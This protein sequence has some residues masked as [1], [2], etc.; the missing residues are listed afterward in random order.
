MKKTEL[1]IP[2][3]GTEQ[4]IAAVENGA[5]AV[6]VGGR[7][8]NARMNADNFSDEEMQ[9]AVDFAHV[10][11]VKVYVAMNTLVTDE[12]LAE[13]ADYAGFLYEAGVD[14]LI[15]QD[16]GLGMLIRETMSDFPLHFST[17]GSVYD[18]RGVETAARLGYERVV[19]ARELSFNE[20]RYICE[21]TDTEIEVFVHGAL[22]VC[23][24]GQCQLSRCHGGRSGNRGEC[25]QPCRLEYK[26]FDAVGRAVDTVRYPLSPKD[27]CLIDHI[28]EL[29]E[30]GVASLKVEG[31]MKSPEY[32]AI[33]TSIYR[34]YLDEY[35][36]NGSYQVTADDREALTQIFSRGGFT[37]G[38]WNGDPG[39]E[40]MSGNIPKHQ[41]VR[42]GKVIKKVTG[43]CLVD[44]KL[45]D[46]LQIGDGVEIHGRH[47]TGNIVTYYKDLKGG[48]TRIGDIKGQV[49]HGDILYRTSRKS[50][51][52]DARRSFENK[53]FAE[54]RFLRKRM[55]DMV[56]SADEDGMISLSVSLANSPGRTV[57]STAESQPTVT[58]T[59]GSFDRADDPSAAK[60]RMENSLR[61]T[62]STPFAVAEI[63]FSEGFDRMAPSSAIN[64]LRRRALSEL[65]KCFI[66]RR[67]KAA[68][69]FIWNAPS[70]SRPKGLEFW[71][72]TWEGFCSFTMPAEL[73]HSDA[74]KALII[75]VTAFERH[76]GELREMAEAAAGE[77]VRII[78]Y[79]SDISKGAEDDYI[80][81]HF[82]SICQ[83]AEASGIY[84]GSLS[85]VQPF[86]SEGIRVYGDYGLNVC[87]R[88][89]AA[90][91]AGIGIKG[92]ASSLE[93]MPADG[94][95]GSFPYMISQ[96]DPE[97]DW[98][99][100]RK[101]A[102]IRIVRREES[103][104]TLLIPE[105]DILNIHAIR[106]ALNQENDNE[107]V[108]IYFI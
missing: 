106:E 14:A 20:I 95:M 67:E 100:D 45:Y 57:D 47:V 48:L 77:G 87:N 10:R 15:I 39:M 89:S 73:M 88:S 6:Y 99:L 71:F 55:I 69:V 75:P 49:E 9:A 84:V 46:S 35:Y 105:P 76:F 74:E 85:W 51:L 59:A 52:L 101:K 107:I 44:V 40:L 103:D 5:D 7:L 1:L 27:L 94:S 21:N 43:G 102:R 97:G 60:E 18:L 31:R 8:F 56:L 93:M 80:E 96:H 37:E 17:Q 23:Y 24:S 30:A 91:Y 25:A 62:G 11:G 54:G 86:R 108:R 33:V 12:E 78:P 19:L 29:A 2:A 41:G 36:A 22:C 68:P 92:C 70:E 65:E 81:E 53:T 50:Q 28:G 32:V 63:S 66:V 79:T 34:K 72:A 83:H 38:Y 42:I 26:T 16:A 82:Q 104:Q 90:A 64:D 13:A 58:V 3:G 4:F 98:L 61:K